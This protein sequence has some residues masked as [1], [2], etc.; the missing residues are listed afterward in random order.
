MGV[1]ILYI[2]HD[3]LSVA[4]IADRIA[5]MHE[6]EIVE[7]R[8]A[9]AIFSDPQH[10]Y[11]H[12]LIAALPSLPGRTEPGPHGILVKSHAVGA[13]VSRVHHHVPR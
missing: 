9:E 8:E 11:T 5:V 6:G 3:L 2:G 13:S 4:S 12:S 7:C 10:P 1:A